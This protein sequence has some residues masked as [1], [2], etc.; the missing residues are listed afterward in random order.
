[1][2]LGGHLSPP[3]AYSDAGSTLTAERPIEGRR[4]PH[5]VPVVI[6]KPKPK[7]KKKL[8]DKNYGKTISKGEALYELERACDYYKIPYSQRPWLEDAMLDIVWDGAHESSGGIHTRNGGMMQ[9]QGWSQTNS[10]KRLAKRYHHRHDSD[11]WTHCAQC[12]IRRFAK[13][14]KDGGKNTIR[15]H[16]KATYG[17]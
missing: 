4:W 2:P 1:M 17:R 9:F 15:T 5:T 7:T 11:G 12:S 10:V 13:A 14:Y 8:V 3:N 16:W 6:E